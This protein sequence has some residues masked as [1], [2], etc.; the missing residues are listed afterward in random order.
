MGGD[1]QDCAFCNCP[2]TIRSIVLFRLHKFIYFHPWA[3]R[4]TWHTLVKSVFIWGSDICRHVDFRF[5][6]YRSTMCFADFISPPWEPPF[7]GQDLKAQKKICEFQTQIDK[8]VHFVILAED[9]CWQ[10]QPHWD[11]VLYGMAGQRGMEVT[12]PTLVSV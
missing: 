1:Y 3:S 5:K 11:A 4:S 9:G 6:S 8:N 7:A 10:P 12:T 2:S